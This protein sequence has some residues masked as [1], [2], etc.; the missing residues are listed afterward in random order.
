[1]RV[2]MGLAKNNHPV[3]FCR[4]ITVQY[5][6][7]FDNPRGSKPRSMSLNFPQGTPDIVVLTSPDAYSHPIQ[8]RESEWSPL[9]GQL[10]ALGLYTLDMRAY[11]CSTPP[12]EGANDAVLDTSR[13]VLIEDINALG[14]RVFTPGA[15]IQGQENFK[16]LAKSLGYPQPDGFSVDLGR[17]DH[18]KIQFTIAGFDSP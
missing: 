18:V 16:T 9:K 8:V 11:L 5:G 1:M 4:V 2:R 10:Q 6:Y 3:H 17:M 14:W 12:L 13:P 7:V 15:T